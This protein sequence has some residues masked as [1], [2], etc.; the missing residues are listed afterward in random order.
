M[1]VASSARAQSITWARS[2]RPASVCRTFGRSEFIRLPCP[3]ARMTTL[4]GMR[5]IISCVRRRVAD[6]GLNSRALL[7]RE[8]QPRLGSPPEHVFG[9][10]GPFAA[11]EIVDF[12]GVEVSAEGD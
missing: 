4:S 1:R 10:P 7:R 5:A 3:A 6:I 2:G 8:V 12:P 11:H 9:A